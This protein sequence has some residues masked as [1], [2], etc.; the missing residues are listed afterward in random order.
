M[1]AI[2]RRRSPEMVT[3]YADD[4]GLFKTR[5]FQIGMLLLLVAYLAVPNTLDDFWIGVLNYCAFFAIGGI[6][7]N[8]LTGY[9]GQVS[10][11]HAFFVGVGAYSAAWFGGQQGWPMLLWLPMAALIGGALGALIGPVALRLHGNYLAI[12][13]LGLL[14]LGEHIFIEWDSVTGGSRGTQVDASLAVGPLDF[15]ALE[16]FGTTFSR[17]QGVFWLL[18]AVVGI[19]ALIAKNVVRTRP[20]RAMQAIR[21]R[22]VAAEVVG[23]SLVRYKVGAFA[24]SSAMAAVA[25][26]FYGAAIQRYVSPVEFGGTF[27]L[28]LSITFVA[29]IIVGGMGTV[30]GSILGALVVGA[31]PRIIQEY[32]GDIPFLQTSPTSDGILSVASF[33]NMLF[34]ALIIVFLLVEPRGLAALWLRAK[35]WFKFWPFSY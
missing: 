10:L 19:C 25:G 23:V 21:D 30:F 9:T 24:I 31:L 32:S 17:E 26:A 35:A 1:A 14:F 6:G 20:G 18:W 3:E 34:G 5:G 8:L 33:N 7:L 2:R 15:T 16:L 4:V 22:D 12:V 13:T 11:G 28:I 29:V 27:G